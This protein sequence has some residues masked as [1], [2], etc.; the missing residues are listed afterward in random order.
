M[1]LQP[2]FMYQYEQAGM[3]E[4][5]EKANVLDCIE[6]GACTYICPGRLYL[7][8]SFRAG[9]QKINNARA[10]AKA[11]AEAA[12]KAEAEKAEKKEAKA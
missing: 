3:L 8:Q 9:K 12:A 5:L 10:A 2:V 7:V 6:C 11:A 1:H 4:E